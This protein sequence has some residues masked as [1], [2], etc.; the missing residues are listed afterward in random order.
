[1]K[2][3]T[4][5][6][7]IVKMEDGAGY[8]GKVYDQYVFIELSN[9]K[10]ISLFDGDMSASHDLLSKI[11]DITI[12]VIF[13]TVEKLS[14]PKYG[15]EPFVPEQGKH[16][17]PGFGHI[18]FGKIEEM[19]DRHHRLSVDI[20]VGKIMVSPGQQEYKTFQV[21]DFVKI[22]TSRADLFRIYD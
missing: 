8:E 19:C 5:R 7:K 18:F 22:L 16:Y 4:V 9:V 14:E 3:P 21:G 15:V 1:M 6:A 10:V 2:Y 12:D 20:G 11:R 17:T 13:A